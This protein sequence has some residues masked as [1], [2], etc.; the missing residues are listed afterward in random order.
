M[1]VL[2]DYLMKY[3]DVTLRRVARSAAYPVSTKIIKSVHEEYGSLLVM[4]EWFE[5]GC[6]QGHWIVIK[7]ST[8]IDGEK[9]SRVKLDNYSE[10]AYVERMYCVQMK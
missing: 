3:T 1:N 5:H 10:T 7:N 8:V 6:N 4:L 2:A 9:G